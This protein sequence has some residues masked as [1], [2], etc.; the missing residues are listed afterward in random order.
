MICVPH[1]QEQL[2]EHGKCEGRGGGGRC[3]WKNI[4]SAEPCE[5][6]AGSCLLLNAIMSLHLEFVPSMIVLNPETEV[7][8]PRSICLFSSNRSY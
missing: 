5:V 6:I 8:F 1:Q 4:V 2:E 7:L 3:E